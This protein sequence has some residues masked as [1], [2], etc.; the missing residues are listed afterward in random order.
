MDLETRLLLRL[1][2]RDSALAV[3]VLR[4]LVYG[5]RGPLETGGEVDWVMFREPFPL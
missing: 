5:D 3:A 2:D 1:V 4:W